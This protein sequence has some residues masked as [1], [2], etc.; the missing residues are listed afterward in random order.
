V[1]RFR[2]ARP[3]LSR[4]RGRRGTVWWAVTGSN[5]R[6]SRCKRWT[7]PH[8]RDCSEF[9]EVTKGLRCNAFCGCRIFPRA[10]KVA[11]GYSRLLPVCFRKFGAAP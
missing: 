3:P 1:W 2:I 4:K 9:P 7:R 6:P 10:L 11:P 5:R 8:T